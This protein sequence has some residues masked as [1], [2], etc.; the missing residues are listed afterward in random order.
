MRLSREKITHLSHL[1]VRTLGQ[2]EGVTLEKPENTIRLEVVRVITDFLTEDANMEER[3]KHRIRSQK[4][5]IPEGSDEW[6]VLLRR[7]YQ[8]EMDKLAVHWD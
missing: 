6:E 7:Y 1:I 8:E 5:T 3:A 4:R 2:T